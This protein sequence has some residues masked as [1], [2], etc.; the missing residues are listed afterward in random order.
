MCKKESDASKKM[1]TLFISY[2][3]CDRPI[4]D[5]IQNKICE[6]LQ[7]KIKIS[8]FDDLKYKESFRSF[9]NTICEHDFVLSVVSDTYLKRKACMYEISEVLKNHHYKE[10]L[11]FVVLSESERTFY[12]DHIP[13]KIGVDIYDRDKSKLKYTLFW[14]EQY[15]ELEEQLQQVNSEEAKKEIINELQII[16][17]IYRKDIGEFLKFLS[18]ENGKNFKK[19]Y[20]NEFED[21][22]QLIDKSSQLFKN[23]FEHLIDSKLEELYLRFPHN[24]DIADSFANSLFKLSLNEDVHIISLA[25]DYLERIYNEHP[26]INFAHIL[27]MSLTNLSVNQDGEGIEKTLSRV[28]SLY[29]QYSDCLEMAIV[30]TKCLVNCTNHTEVVADVAITQLQELCD[31]YIGNTEI[32]ANYACGLTN[33]FSLRKSQETQNIVECL[34]KLY[35]H[36]PDE[37]EIAIKYAKSLKILSSRQ[38]V[39][40]AILTAKRIEQLCIQN[41][42]TID[43]VVLYMQCLVNLCPRESEVGVENLFTCIEKLYK[44]NPDEPKIISGYAMGIYNYQRKQKL[45]DALKSV[46]RMEDLYDKYPCVPETFLGLTRCL[47]DLSTK[48]NEEVERLYIVARLEYLL[49]K[50]MNE[51]VAV[52]YAIGLYNLSLKQNKDGVITTLA[53]FEELYKRYPDNERIASEFAC[54]MERVYS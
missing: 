17:Q 35:Q 44:Q 47:V 13:K 36:Y 2:T 45:E 24:T 26:C 19:L 22:I 38:N 33:W 9:M 42:N 31:L 8:R 28:Q 41:P 51:D 50:H 52:G 29:L 34:E 48:Q 5:L 37:P 53:R 4:V 7:N 15:N 27:A 21:L 32:A 54:F 6:K 40:D 39:S 10:K 18:D 11:I 25:V 14:Q 1:V 30:Y 16:G 20:E 3:S 49:N 43:I 23:K 12:Q 46:K